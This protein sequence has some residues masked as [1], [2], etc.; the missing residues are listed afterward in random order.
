MTN[1][2]PL[3]GNV[4]VLVLLIR[5]HS[6]QRLHSEDTDYGAKHI[7]LFQIEICQVCSLLLDV[8]NCPLYV[9]RL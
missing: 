4:K 1:W 5:A 9:N 8:G 6:M 2:K 3:L 7:G